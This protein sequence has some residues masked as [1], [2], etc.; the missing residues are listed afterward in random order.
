AVLYTPSDAPADKT[1]R[2]YRAL[3]REAWS[4]GAAARAL[5]ARPDADLAAAPNAFESVGASLF[6]DLEAARARLLAAGAPWARLTGA[7][8]T[9]FALLPSEAAARRVQ[10]GV[11]DPAR[12]LV[13]PT[14]PRL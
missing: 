14:L 9:L 10:V 8:P 3:A 13:A 7:G 12:C 4:D 11:G 5:A 6:P 2:A 1:A